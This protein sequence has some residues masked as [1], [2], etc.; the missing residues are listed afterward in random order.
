MAKMA[1]NVRF[2]QLLAIFG[3]FWP[4]LAIFGQKWPELNLFLLVLSVVHQITFLIG[5]KFEFAIYFDI[6]EGS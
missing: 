4:F 2:G 3:H 6:L 1:Q 5:V